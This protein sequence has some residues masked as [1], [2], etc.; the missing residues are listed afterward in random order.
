MI[1]CCMNGAVQSR[2]SVWSAQWMKLSTWYM[3]IATSTAKALEVS[4]QRAYL[5]THTSTSS[6][7]TVEVCVIVEGSCQEVNLY[8]SSMKSKRKIRVDKWS[9][10][11]F[12]CSYASAWLDCDKG[13]VGQLSFES[14]IPHDLHNGLYPNF[15]L[16]FFNCPSLTQ[17]AWLPH[18]KIDKKSLYAS[19]PPLP[20]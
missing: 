17:N 2:S 14:M 5:S 11:A 15:L 1:C 7:N 8:S 18:N 16:L 9:G 19:L 3:P 4:S 6:N 13:G 20:L 12:T 10:T